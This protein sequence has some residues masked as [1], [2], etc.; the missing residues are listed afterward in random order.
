MANINLQDVH[1]LLV[2]VAKEAGQMIMGATPTQ[3]ASGTKKNST[4]HSPAL[5]EFSNTT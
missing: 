3:A 4:V 1:D 5:L 2:S